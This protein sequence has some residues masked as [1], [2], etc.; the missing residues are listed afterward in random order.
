M[1]KQAWNIKEKQKPF[2]VK[3]LSGTLKKAN[4][5]KIRLQILGK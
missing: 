4:L 2:F 1:N 3:Y 5:R